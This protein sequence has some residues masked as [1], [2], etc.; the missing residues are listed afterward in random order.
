MHH[1]KSDLV[2]LNQTLCI[3]SVSVTYLKEYQLIK[4]KSSN[5]ILLNQK[6]V[7]KKNHWNKNVNKLIDTYV[8]LRSFDP[9]F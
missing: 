1:Y 7:E 4:K 6:N 2:E 9:N 3:K 8:T 5:L